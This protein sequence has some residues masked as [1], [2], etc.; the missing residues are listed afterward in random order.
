MII[1]KSIIKIALIISLV[2]LIFS[3]LFLIIY[4]EINELNINNFT[5][6][7]IWYSLMYTMWTTFISTLALII[8]SLLRKIN[9]QKVWSYIKSETILLLIVIG[10]TALIILFYHH[11][12]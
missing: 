1:L 10:F 6:I 8:I 9:N 4:G 11:Q 5:S 3:T 7:F 2:S 12:Y